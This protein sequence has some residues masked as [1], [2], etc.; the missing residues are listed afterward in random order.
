MA[1]AFAFAFAFALSP[2]ATGDDERSEADDTNVSAGRAPEGPN[3][4][5][6][7]QRGQLILL[8][9]VLGERVMPS[10]L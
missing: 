3:R 10:F 8:L 2:F 9:L 4:A 6:T 1:I 5:L 7:S